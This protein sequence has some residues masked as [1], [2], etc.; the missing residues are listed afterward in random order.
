[1]VPQV[2]GSG[3]QDGALEA[4]ISTAMVQMLHRRTGRGPLTG[5][6]VSAF[7]SCNHREPDVA[8][9]VFVLSRCA[10]CRA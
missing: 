7:M 6:T 8:A 4:A 3:A 9:R 5:R 2:E 1:M 10:G